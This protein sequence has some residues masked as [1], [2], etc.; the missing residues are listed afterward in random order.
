VSISYFP[1]VR[2]H[3]SFGH[4]HKNSQKNVDRQRVE[5]ENVRQCRFVQDGGEERLLAHDVATAA[6]FAP[7]EFSTVAVLVWC[8]AFDDTGRMRRPVCT[9]EK[10]ALAPVKTDGGHLPFPRRRVLSEALR[11]R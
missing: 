11:G 1:G 7:G 6:G 3:I 4:R 9:L 2:V 5:A 8:P 10:G